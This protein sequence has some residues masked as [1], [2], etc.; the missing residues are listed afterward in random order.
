MTKAQNVRTT[1]AVL[2]APE[3]APIANIKPS[4]TTVEVVDTRGRKIVVKKL[5]ALAKANLLRVVGAE[6][7]QNQAYF[8]YVLAA[9]SV[10]SIDGELENPPRTQIAID[11]LLSQL[12]DEGVAA[13]QDAFMD[14]YGDSTT[15][16]D[17]AAAKN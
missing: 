5:N 8:G 13:V 7:A 1:A 2:A 4:G 16:E 15:A 10:A 3:S 14:L 9:A 17:L 6:A 11:A 12:D